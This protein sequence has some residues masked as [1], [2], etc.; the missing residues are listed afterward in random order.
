MGNKTAKTGML[1]SMCNIVETAMKDRKNH[2]QAGYSLVELAVVLLIVGIVTA[3]GVSMLSEDTKFNKYEQTHEEMIDIDDGLAVFLSQNDRLP[4]P[5]PLTAVKGD[6]T[7]ARETDCT[8]TT[9]PAGTFRIEHPASS[10]NYVRIG[11]AP[12]YDMEMPDEYVADAWYGKYLYAVSESL[13]ST[14][15]SSSTGNIT[16]QDGASADIQTEVAWVVVSMGKDTMGAYAARTD[17]MILNC[18]SGTLDEENCDYNNGIFR[19]TTFND[20]SIT[21]NYF[22][23][24]IRWETVPQLYNIQ[25]T[26]GGGGGGSSLPDTCTSGQIIEYNGSNWVCGTDNAGTT[27]PTCTSGQIVEFNGSNWVCA[28]DEDNE[29]PT[30]TA[31]ETIFFDGTNWIC[32]PTCASG[33]SLQFD[34]TDWVCATP[35]GGGGLPTC[36]SGQT[37]QFDGTDWVC[38]SSGGGNAAGIPVEVR[39]TLATNNGNF[40]GW[41]GIK[42]FIADN[43]CSGDFYVCTS[44]DILKAVQNNVAISGRG[45]VAAPLANID[46]W[47][48]R[49]D[50]CAAWSGTSSW[51]HY[52]SVWDGVTSRFEYGFC[53]DPHPVLCCKFVE[54]PPPSGPYDPCNHC[55][56]PGTIEFTSNGTW[57][58]PSNVNGCNFSI[59]MIASTGQGYNGDGAGLGGRVNFDFTP[60]VK[61]KP[62][63][64]R[65]NGAAA[66]AYNDDVLAVAGEGGN[67]GVMVCPIDYVQAGH[68]A[69]RP[70]GIMTGEA[71]DS[72]TFPNLAGG[73]GGSGPGTASEVPDLYISGS[74][75]SGYGRGGP[76]YGAGGSGAS[77]IDGFCGDTHVAAGGGGGGYVNTSKVTNITY[78]ALQFRTSPRITIDWSVPASCP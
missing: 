39:P 11:A 44:N 77:Q 20:G 33:E 6:S 41:S 2:R 71:G 31:D 46:R 10:G 51:A 60:T 12:I 5:A 55:D 7:Y 35:S 32:S 43:G 58:I 14:M 56:G 27:L 70:G 54:D 74:G 67:A 52:G 50:N 72:I 37:I 75:G 65:M 62:F 76:G 30:C 40:G 78:P 38:A 9:P 4:C 1:S 69:P 21:A 42:T 23:D 66:V 73:A 8:D 59:S 25:L 49:L 48:R 63:T 19:D 16:V 64:F 24:I 61:G 34:G 3:G 15:T 29:L 17:N 57:N 36:T 68:G 47:D 45:W 22:D 53:D 18:A 13:T 28:A 26:V